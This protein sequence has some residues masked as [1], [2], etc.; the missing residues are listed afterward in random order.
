MNK[1][2]KEDLLPEGKEKEKDY[3]F[4]S[5]KNLLNKNDLNNSKN[6]INLNKYLRNFMDKDVDDLLNYLLDKVYKDKLDGK[7]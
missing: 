5:T 3:N 6:S 4:R 1:D 2:S 7:Y